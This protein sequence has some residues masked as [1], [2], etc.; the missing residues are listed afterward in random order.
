[1]L[2]QNKPDRIRILFDDHRLV[3]NAGLLLPD[4]RPAARELVDHHHRRR[5]GTGAMLTLVASGW[6]ALRR[7]SRSVS[8]GDTLGTFLDR[9]IERHLGR[10][11]RTRRAPNLTCQTYAQ[12]RSRTVAQMRENRAKRKLQR[13]EVVTVISGHQSPDMIDFLGQFGFDAAWLEGEHGPIDSADIP[14]LTRACDLWGMTSV[15]RVNLNIPGV[16]RYHT[17]D[18]GAYGGTPGQSR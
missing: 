3:A 13:G 11:G 6:P 1:M 18:V 2:P 12:G 15:V 8:Q 17:L 14:D 5:A 9:R 16:I 7:C 4:P 10:W